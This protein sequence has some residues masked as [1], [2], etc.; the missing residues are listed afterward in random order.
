[1]SMVSIL[2]AISWRAP[3]P[4]PSVRREAARQRPAHPVRRT[5]ADGEPAFKIGLLIDSLIGGGAERIV[6]NL[7]Q[8]FQAMGHEVHVILVRNQV[9]HQVPT[10]ITR[11]ALSQDGKLCSNRVLNK[12]MLAWA[13]KRSVARIEADGHAFDFFISNAEDADRISR[14]AGLKNVYIRYRNSMLGYLNNKLG[15]K[16]GLKRLI[17]NL[18]WRLRFRTIYSGRDIITVADALQREMVD[19]IGV[20]PKSIVTIYNPFDFARIRQ[21]GELG[22]RP[23]NEPYIV[24]VAKIEQRKRQDVLLRAYAASRSRQT[25]KLVLLGGTY[26]QSDRNWQ[27]RI[28]QLIVELGLQEQVILAGFHTNPYPWIKHAAL[29]AMS[30]DNEGL[31]TV[32]IES[33]I[34]GTPVVSTDCPTGPRE[35][36]NGPLSSF[37]SPCG[38]DAALARNIDRVIE[39]AYPAITSRQLLRFQA[40]YSAGRYLEHCVPVHH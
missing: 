12:L 9:E 31:P 14:I 6:L 38:D 15:S 28:E 7:A 25:H 13:L 17:R 11:H 4:Q 1:M 19:E 29:F 5:T 22:G 24:Y 23:L 8:T 32:L 34:L 21:Q 26:T 27:T 3:L 33:L 2:H 16:T 18:R 10:S 40:T 30:S 36:L 37:L 20:R 35:I 39:G